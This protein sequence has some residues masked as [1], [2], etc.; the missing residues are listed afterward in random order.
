MPAQAA[1]ELTE[2]TGLGYSR[3]C[4]SSRLWE[5]RAHHQDKHADT[6][7]HAARPREGR[8]RVTNRYKT[9]DLAAQ[10]P[11]A[12]AAPTRDGLKHTSG[13]SEGLLV[14]GLVAGLVARLVAELGS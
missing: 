3:A 14:A 7:G 10:A 13:D 1:R 12:R 9:R 4:S 2:P 11:S 8:A 6:A 5:K